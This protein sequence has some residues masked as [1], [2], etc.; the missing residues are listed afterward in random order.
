MGTSN[1][2][3]QAVSIKRC[4]RVG[5]DMHVHAPPADA[6]HIVIRQ[7]NSISRRVGV[8]VAAAVLAHRTPPHAARP[9]GAPRARD[10]TRADRSFEPRAQAHRAPR[11]GAGAHL[12]MVHTRRGASCRLAA[13]GS[14]L[15]L[16]RAMWAGP[17]HARHFTK[18][19]VALLRTT[20]AR[21]RARPRPRRCGED[22][23]MCA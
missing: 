4:H 11:S 10:T 13:H 16:A 22:T 6:D 17:P 21:A 1:T 3:T 20:C 7:G 5:I 8:V 18:Q 15:R 19:L 14:R 2:T 23:R 12:L 9:C